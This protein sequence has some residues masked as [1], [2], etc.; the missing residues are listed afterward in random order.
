MS[1]FLHAIYRLVFYR[2]NKKKTLVFLFRAAGKLRKSSTQIYI[3]YY[4]PS[5]YLLKRLVFASIFISRK[6]GVIK[7]CL[8]EQK[9]TKIR[10]VILFFVNV[11]KCVYIIFLVKYLQFVCLFNFYF[12]KRF[13]NIAKFSFKLYLNLY[14]TCSAS[15]KNV[16]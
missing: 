10:N 2:P 15:Q 14:N 1:R 16:L 4:H 8:R 13:N 12:L 9:H 5:I 7:I 3:S 11:V 6:K